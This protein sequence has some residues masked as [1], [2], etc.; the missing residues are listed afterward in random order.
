MCCFATDAC[1]NTPS[2]PKLAHS[3][4]CVNPHGMLLHCTAPG[5][6]TAARVGGHVGVYAGT[7]FDILLGL[8]E[9]NKLPEWHAIYGGYGY[10]TGPA[11]SINAALDNGLCSKLTY[12]FMVG[13]TM[14]WLTCVKIGRNPNP[15]C[16]ES[17]R[18]HGRI[19]ASRLLPGRSNPAVNFRVRWLA[20]LC[21]FADVQ[22]SDDVIA[23]EATRTTRTPS[24]TRQV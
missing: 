11:G 9:G 12:Q 4:P 6:G 2:Y 22:S 8:D 18:G 23:F 10:A 16:R 21:S 3:S 1:N 5:T 19:A 24:S 13:G 7:G 15:L 14:G 20:A 17:A